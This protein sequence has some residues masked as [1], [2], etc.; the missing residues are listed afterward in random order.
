M[1]DQPII[2]YLT[3]TDC[4]GAIEHYKAALGATENSRMP[5]SE[6]DP[7][8]IHAC[9]TVGNGHIFMMDAFPEH[10]GRPAT[11]EPTQVSMVVQLKAPAEVDAYFARATGAGMTGTMP[12]SDQFWGARFASVIDKYGHSWMFNAQLP[13]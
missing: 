5:C 3:L 9:L 12:P 1:M 10:N 2:P 6:T 11:N 7:R 8:I 13:G 4:A